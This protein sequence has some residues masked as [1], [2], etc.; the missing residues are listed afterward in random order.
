MLT[1]DPARDARL[2][3][4]QMRHYASLP[5]ARMREIEKVIASRCPQEFLNFDREPPQR[6]RS[7]IKAFGDPA[8]FHEWERLRIAAE[9]VDKQIR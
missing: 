2:A 6:Q 9:E 1:S 4:E 5:R 8:E 7:I 3:R